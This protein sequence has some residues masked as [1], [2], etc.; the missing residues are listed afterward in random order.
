MIVEKGKMPISEMF[1]KYGEKY[2]RDLE[3]EVMR[4]ISKM[5]NLIV[6]CGGG[7][8]LKEENVILMRNSGTVLWLQRDI[9]KVIESVKAE[10]RPLLKD[11][12]EKL[13]SIFESRKEKYKNAAHYIIDNNKGTDIT[14]KEILAYIK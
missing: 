8:I 6:S 5:N 11:G 1:A 13:Y 3:T 4:E 10:N 2:F 7:V 14:I 12:K 9:E